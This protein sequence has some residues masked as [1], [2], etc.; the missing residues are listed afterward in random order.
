M[1]AYFCSG[2][3]HLFNVINLQ[4][5]DED[6]KG[7]CYIFNCFIDAEKRYENL[8]ETGIFNN[9]YLIHESPSEYSFIKKGKGFFY[10]ARKTIKKSIKSLKK[11][12]YQNYKFGSFIYDEIFIPGYYAFLHRYFMVLAKNNKKINFY[13]EGL[14]C[15]INGFTKPPIKFLGKIFKIYEYEKAFN[16]AYM[17]DFKF[18]EE[19]FNSLNKCLMTNFFK[20]NRDLFYKIFDIKKE[21][22]EKFNNAKIVILPTGISYEPKGDNSQELLV[23]ENNLYKYVID[24]YDNVVLK[25]HPGSTINFSCVCIDKSIPFELLCASENLEDK[26]FLTSFSTTIFNIKYLFNKEPNIILLYKVMNLPTKVWFNK[27]EEESDKFM[28]KFLTDAY[29]KKERVFIPN[30]TEEFKDIL[31]RINNEIKNK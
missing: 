10:E 8:K 21:E 15:R 6:E 7:D 9:V 24:N 13:D 11:N 19:K 22:I 29:E 2:I 23:N 3:Y 12:D 30:G 31:E 4:L 20:M 28:R 14:G 26:I 17:Y 16:N 1:K 25:N 5:M 27:N 18:A